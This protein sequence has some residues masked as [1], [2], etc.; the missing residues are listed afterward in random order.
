[1]PI[2]VDVVVDDDDDDDD[3]YYSADITEPSW[4][5]NKGND[6]DEKNVFS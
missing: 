2:D 6:V 4:V 3:D 1:L 5:D